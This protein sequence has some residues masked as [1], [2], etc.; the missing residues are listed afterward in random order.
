VTSVSLR[1][2]TWKIRWEFLL[3]RL[4]LKS[5]DEAADS[6]TRYF[7]ERGWCYGG[8]TRASS[9]EELLKQVEDELENSRK[10]EPMPK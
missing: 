8:V 9:P 10:V 3:A 5:R 2:H 1:K 6:I 4:R 7:L